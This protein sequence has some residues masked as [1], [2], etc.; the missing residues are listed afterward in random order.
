MFYP[1]SG[2]RHYTSG[3]LAVTLVYVMHHTATGKRGFGA[4]GDLLWSDYA[5]PQSQGF[6]VRCV[7]DFKTSIVSKSANE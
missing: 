3:I 5:D 4:Y 7:R 1:A 2:R 6:T